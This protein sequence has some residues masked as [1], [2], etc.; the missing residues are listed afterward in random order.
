MLCICASDAKPP[1][2]GI[3]A[4]N[5]SVLHREA[6]RGCV[7]HTIYGQAIQ[8]DQVRHSKS[9]SQCISSSHIYRTSCVMEI[10][11]MRLHASDPFLYFGALIGLNIAID[12][13]LEHEKA[14]AVV[15]SP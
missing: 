8:G 10:V 14:H 4:V 11:S 9:Q 7:V 5:G 12:Q 6:W 15:V 13:M 1:M 3:D 2:T